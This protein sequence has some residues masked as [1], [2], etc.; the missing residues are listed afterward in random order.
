[1]MKEFER[2][3]EEHKEQEKELAEKAKKAGKSVAAFLG[4]AKKTKP[5]KKPTQP[6]LPKTSESIATKIEA[7]KKKIDDLKQEKK[8]TIDKKTVS[9]ITSRTNYCDPRITIAWCKRTDVPV[10]KLFSKTLQD[11]F[12][13]ALDCPKDYAF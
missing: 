5:P 1:M 8:M 10:S 2:L 13:W 6:I 7:I 11:K 9:L 4:S 3:V 12:P